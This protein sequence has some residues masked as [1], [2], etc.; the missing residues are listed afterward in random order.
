VLVVGI[1]TVVGTIVG[2]GLTEITLP[3]LSQAWAASLGGVEIRRI[4]V[5]WP[6]VLRLYGVLAGC[7]ALA[8][9]CSLLAL[10][11]TSVLGALRLSEE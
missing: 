11:R 8:M 10:A 4:V 5:V 9:G 7:Y 2:Y 1:G 3:Y 6:A